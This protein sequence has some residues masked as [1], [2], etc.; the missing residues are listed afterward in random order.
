MSLMRWNFNY[1][2]GL[3][4]TTKFSDIKLYVQKDP[5]DVAQGYIDKDIPRVMFYPKNKFYDDT[6]H[7]FFNGWN[8]VRTPF[9]YFQGDMCGGAF[10]QIIWNSL[11]VK[12]NDYELAV[13]NNLSFGYVRDDSKRCGLVLMYHKEDPAK[14]MLCIAKNTEK[15]SFKQRKITVFTSQYFSD[16]L[17]KTKRGAKIKED[18]LLQE[19]TKKLGSKLLAEAFNTF[20][21]PDGR[22]DLDEIRNFE[23]TQIS[24]LGEKHVID[25]RDKPPPL[26]PSKPERNYLL[27]LVGGA[28]GAMAGFMV[29]SFLLGPMFAVPTLGL[30]LLFAPVVCAL[31]GMLAGS[32]IGMTISKLFFSCVNHSKN[33]PPIAQT[34]HAKPTSSSH[35][36]IAKCGI[37]ADKTQ[38]LGDPIITKSKI[39]KG[40]DIKFIPYE[41]SVELS[42]GVSRRNYFV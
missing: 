8:N 38:A 11:I 39:L 1:N 13:R 6:T 29:G 15:V 42:E 20:I 27:D 9:C 32:L 35:A 14:W 2:K 26:L 34:H 21:K 3:T 24:F 4:W 33:P 5:A 25:P 10:I 22:L 31:A 12:T 17:K 40:D 18:N 28:A 37:R 36:N 19:I 41:S 23:A 7:Y 30:S 16:I